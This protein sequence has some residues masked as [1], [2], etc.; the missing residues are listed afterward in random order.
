ML[1]R[2]AYGICALVLILIP[3]IMLIIK[4]QSRK[5]DWTNY[6]PREVY[7][8]GYEFDLFRLPDEA[9]VEAYYPKTTHRQTIRPLSSRGDTVLF[10]TYS[11]PSGLRGRWETHQRHE[12]VFQQRFE[13]E[14][15]KLQ[16]KIPASARLEVQIPDSV[17]PYLASTNA[18]QA[19]HPDIAG[20]AWKFKAP[21]LKRT[22]R[23]NFRYVV[24]ME[25]SGSSALTDALTTYRRKR[26]S[27]N[28][29]SRLFVALCR[30]QGI[31][32][33]G[34]GGIILNEGEKRTSHLWT[35]I[36]YKGYWMPFDIMNEHFATLPANYLR[37][38]HG[39]EYL[40]AHTPKV[41]FDYQ[42]IIQKKHQSLDSQGKHVPVLWSLLGHRLVSIDLL[43]TILLLPLGCLLIALFKNVI[44]LKTL[45]IFLPALI[46]LSLV[47][48]N[49]YWTIAAFTAVLAVIS[50]LHY[51]LNQLGLLHTPKLVIMLLSVIITLVLL[52]TLGFVMQWEKWPSVFMLPLV[53]MALAAERFAKVLTEDGFES[54]AKILGSTLLVALLCYPVFQ[55]DILI[56]L[57]LTYP[58]LYL[59]MMGILLLLG[60]WIG[61]RIMERYR[62]APLIPKNA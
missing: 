42:F 19:D 4:H 22:L 53:I 39:D 47:G 55:S 25:N 48:V 57:L 40:I 24:R 14:G 6:L 2:N 30:A 46:A 9:F 20:Q 33:R 36:Y 60:R 15:K 62:F 58:E 51:N 3:A 11:L 50:A 59:S 56:G 10:S 34:V 61:L 52:G 7:T 38:Y 21:Q 18:I 12:A 54:A 44:G 26:A 45:G 13:F 31:P 5:Q 32:A 35:E 49:V 37:L 17:L 8:V 28:G 43:R 41:G 27:C 16:Y 29:K 23:S 1:K